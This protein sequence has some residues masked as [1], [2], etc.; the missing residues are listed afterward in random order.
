[1]M[2]NIFESLTDISTL[3]EINIEDASFAQF[4]LTGYKFFRTRHSDRGDKWAVFIKNIRVVSEGH[5]F[6]NSAERSRLTTNIASL[7]VILALYVPPTMNTP[8]F[9]KR[10]E[11][12]LAGPSCEVN[13]C[14]VAD[15]SVTSS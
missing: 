15:S 6:F 9:M 2:A 14:L 8:P 5:S 10:F 11:S 13:L 3:S 7:I 1:M 4:V 12:S